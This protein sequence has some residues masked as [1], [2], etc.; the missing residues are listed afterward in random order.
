MSSYE[1][2]LV[3]RPDPAVARIVMNRPDA[4]NAQNL[5]MTYDLNAAFDD[6]VQDDSVKVIIL[7]G[8][9]PHFSAGHDL[10]ATTKNEAGIDFPP[11][12]AWGGFREPGAHGRMAREQ[13]IYLQIT[14]RWRNLAKPTIAEVHGKCIAGGLMLAWACDLI[15]AADSAEFC[16]PVVT[17]GVCGVEWFVHPWELGPRKAKELLFTA[18][19]W[20]AQEAHQLGM[21]NHVVP[22][23]EL[24]AFT[25]ALAQR[26]AAKPS[27]ALKMTKE[28]VNRSVD[29][30][31]QP[32][33][34]DQA[35]ALHQ[36]C[37]AHNLQEFG[38]IV[39]PSGLHPS[40]RK[41][42]KV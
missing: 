10:R 36:L 8:A 37:H 25:M 2:I 19:S 7:A 9:G 38:M 42:V 28:A 14:R 23:T 33:A 11:I 41:Q 1:T 20:S 40:V 6:A 31:G 32:A 24:S 13:E 17:M 22:A 5:Q 30:Q 27:F 39:D 26:I 21:V 16:D 35:F 12:G 15:V 3:E 29:I 4:R 18:D 34:I